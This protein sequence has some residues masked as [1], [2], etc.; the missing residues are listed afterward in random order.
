LY[1]ESEAGHLVMFRH[2]GMGRAI[3]WNAQSLE[4]EGFL[5]AAV[6]CSD[7]ANPCTTMLHESVREFS[8]LPIT[9]ITGE[10]SSH[11]R[12]ALFELTELGLQVE[13]ISCA[14]GAKAEVIHTSFTSKEADSHVSA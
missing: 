4:T 1:D 8:G 7:E 2:G 10:P 14:D 9:V 13:L 5:L 3:Q 6:V 12:R 11:L